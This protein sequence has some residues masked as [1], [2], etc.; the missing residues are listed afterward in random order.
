MTGWWIGTASHSPG[1]S[2]REAGA[3][4][5]SDKEKHTTNNIVQM[6]AGRVF[7][8]DTKHVTILHVLW[9]WVYRFYN[10]AYSAYNCMYPNDTCMYTIFVVMFSTMCATY[11]SLYVYFI[12]CIAFV[13]PLSRA[14]GLLWAWNCLLGI[15]MIPISPDLHRSQEGE[16]S[17]MTWNWV[18]LLSLTQIK[19]NHLQFLH[20]HCSM[21]KT[22]LLK[23]EWVETIED[24]QI[25]FSA[26]LVKDSVC[27]GVV[28]VADCDYNRD[29][30]HDTVAW[31]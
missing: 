25:T 23:H 21:I 9:D 3:R 26:L 28:R 2:L 20:R 30:Y 29:G 13:S 4:A 31:Q 10:T 19:R 6:V 12:Y 18:E 16:S 1:H 7:K 24:H 22:G 14:M 5:P 8:N 15:W 11:V 27:S 17:K